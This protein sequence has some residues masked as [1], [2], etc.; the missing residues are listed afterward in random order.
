[1]ANCSFS[2]AEQRDHNAVVASCAVFAVADFAFRCRSV[3]AT[4]PPFARAH[5]P[6]ALYEK[7]HLMKRAKYRLSGLLAVLAVTCLSYRSTDAVVIMFDALS[8]GG[9]NFRY[10][11]TL[12]NNEPLGP[13]TSI[14][15]FDIDFEPSRYNETSL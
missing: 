14:Q 6:A 9:S 3:T 12:F 4:A 5:R 8:L 1:Q 10:V 13:V 15:L 7:E 2:N 11:Y